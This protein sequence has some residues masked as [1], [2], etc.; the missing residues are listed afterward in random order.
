MALAAQLDAL[1]ARLPTED[2][3][4]P[5]AD[6]NVQPVAEA[7]RTAVTDL[8]HARAALKWVARPARSEAPNVGPDVATDQAREGLVLEAAALGCSVEELRAELMA[9]HPGLPLVIP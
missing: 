1:L 5:S 7:M 2:L 3:T 9:P 4:S 6:D 8:R